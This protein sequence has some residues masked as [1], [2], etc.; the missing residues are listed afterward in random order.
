MEAS[1]EQEAACGECNMKLYSYPGLIKQVLV[2]LIRNSIDV[3]TRHVERG[4]RKITVAFSVDEKNATIAVWDNGGGIPGS[5]R[6]R[7][8]DPYFTTKDTKES[9]GMG[10]YTSKAVVEQNLKGRIDVENRDGGAVFTVTFPRR[11]D[12]N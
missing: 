9:M 8:F 12:E 10:L 5:I 3:V 11:V 7:I 6:K 4:E 1:L 2:N